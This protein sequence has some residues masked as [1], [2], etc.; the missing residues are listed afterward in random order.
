VAETTEDAGAE[1]EPEP[2]LAEAEPHEI[3]AAAEEIA[4]AAAEESDGSGD[5]GGEAEPV[6]V[7][8]AVVEEIAAEEAADDAGTTFVAVEDAVEVEEVQV[9]DA[10]VL[11]AEMA[12]LRPGEVAQTTIAVWKPDAAAEFRDHLKEVQALFVDEPLAAVSQA[13]S[14]VADAVRALAEALLAEQLDLDPRQHS[15]NPDTEALR[16][17]LRQYR[18]FLERVLAL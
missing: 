5:S 2:Q 10:S 6:F 7:A 4:A 3:V 9:E 16:V 12:P 14:L 1:S 18:N 13:Q 15:E 17:A 11:V 8:V